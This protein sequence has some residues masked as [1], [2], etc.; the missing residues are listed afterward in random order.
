[1]RFEPGQTVAARDLIDCL[2]RC[3]RRKFDDDLVGNKRRPASAIIAVVNQVGFELRT[4]GRLVGE[5]AAGRTGRGGRRRR[6]QLLKQNPDNG[7][8]N[9]D[10]HRYSDI[11]SGFV[12]PAARF[13][14]R[15]TAGHD[16]GWRPRQ[17]LRH[18]RA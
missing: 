11:A 9:A 3:A 4:G 8:A 5:F 17:V 2:R 18:G 14:T 12:A 16:R 13:G 1:M 7:D 10:A 6:G 15:I